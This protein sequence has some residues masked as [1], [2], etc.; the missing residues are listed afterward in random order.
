MTEKGPN[1]Y[2]QDPT[3][4]IYGFRVYM[5][6]GGPYL[7]GSSRLFILE[8]TIY[9]SAQTVNIGEPYRH[10]Q[11][12]YCTRD[13]CWPL[14]LAYCLL[15]D[16]LAPANGPHTVPGCLYLLYTFG[17]GSV[18]K[19]RMEMEEKRE[20]ENRYTVR[21]SCL[22]SNVEDKSEGQSLHQ[23]SEHR[24]LVTDNAVHRTNTWVYSLHV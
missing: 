23:Q 5:Y 3:F 1:C 22:S 6:M 18:C 11:S 12:L 19:R 4:D 2:I 14:M 13:S 10:I 15:Q 21:S 17:C 9:Q 20:K 8:F 16:F 7:V 24:R